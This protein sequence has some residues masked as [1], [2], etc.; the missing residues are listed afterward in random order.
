MEH[1]GVITNPHSRK[2]QRQPVGRVGR[3]QEILGGAGEVRE[4]QS[5][6][7]V[8]PAV[9]DFF[10]KKIEYLVSDGGDGAMHWLLN[11]AR[12][13]A[14]EDEFRS[15]D[16]PL[17]VPTNG[18]TIDFVA[19]KANMRGEGLQIIDALVRT[20]AEGRPPKV[21]TLDS[22]EVDGI[23]RTDRGDEPFKRIGFALA[24]GG[25]G[26]RFFDK[27]YETKNPGVRTILSV[28]SRA[29]GSHLAAQ[30]PLPMPERVLKFGRE[31][32]EPTHARV[33]IDGEELPTTEHGAIHAGAFDISLGGVF[34]VF[35]LAH[36]RGVLHFQA[37]G[38][39][40]SEIIRALPDLYRGGAIRS[41]KMKDVSGRVMEIEAVGDE[42]LC[43]I[44]D[45]EPF[46]GLTRMTVRPGPFIRVARVEA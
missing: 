33:V 9:R 22:F 42:L 29:V 41:R 4:T 11:A 35:P 20:T 38:I 31:I 43:P 44:I 10:R 36:E 34:R 27:Y 24:A 37:G 17:A 5:T 30:V 1:I 16:F 3:L 19:Q 12:S 39:V 21:I 15:L 46:V 13:V 28:V 8:A 6:S 32:F 25:I 45:G 18:G 40:P 2:N 26:Q 23:Q 7:E 14:A